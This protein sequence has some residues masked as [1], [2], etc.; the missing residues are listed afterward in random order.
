MC[1]AWL[2]EGLDSGAVQDPAD[3]EQAVLALDD[4][5]VA[6]LGQFE[7]V[8]V[9]LLVPAD[10]DHP[11][12]RHLARTHR[13][14]VAEAGDEDGVVHVET[15][16]VAHE[17]GGEGLRHLVGFVHGRA[18]DLAVQELGYFPDCHCSGIIFGP[19]LLKSRP[20]RSLKNV[21]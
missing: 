14:V 11:H 7:H 20:E 17:V 12:V 15:Q 19:T 10:Y 5:D 6:V 2:I 16:D 18:E 9:G 8:P 21:S 1:N 3:L 4:G 13:L